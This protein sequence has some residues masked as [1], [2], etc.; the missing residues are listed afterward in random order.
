MRRTTL[1]V[2][3]GA[4]GAILA[5]R[6]AGA[7]ADLRGAPEPPSWEPPPVEEPP[8]EE[9]PVEQA[10]VEDPA[11]GGPPGGTA[12]GGAADRGGR[13]AGGGSRR[14]GRAIGVRRTPGGGPGR[15]GD[16]GPRGATS[17]HGTDPRPSTS[18]TPPRRRSPTW[19]TT[20]WRPSPRRTRSRTRR[21]ST[22]TPGP[23]IAPRATSPAERPFPTFRRR[24]CFHTAFC[25][26]QS[27]VLAVLNG[28][29]RGTH[30]GRKVGLVRPPG[31]IAAWISTTAA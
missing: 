31:R 6:R 8:V 21:W 18:P 19:S 28:G 16:R 13:P 26:E 11:G 25:C 29:E 10:P 1:L 3:L 30:W 2:A 24:I 14:H 9:P 4:A 17:R 27:R 20:S 5:R 7:A 15:G 23:A 22:T 12:H